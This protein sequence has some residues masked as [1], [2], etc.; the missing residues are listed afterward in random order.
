MLIILFDI[1][2]SLYWLIMVDFFIPYSY[3]L[4]IINNYFQTYIGDVLIV[5]NPYKSLD[6]YGEKVSSNQ[7]AQMLRLINVII[8]RDCP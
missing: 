5:I 1:L 3:I 7:L 2:A 4:I 8:M 6:L